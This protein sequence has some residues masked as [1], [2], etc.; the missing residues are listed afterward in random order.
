MFSRR[1]G[2]L[3]HITSLPSPW[4]LGD[5]GPGA[6]EFID[7]LARAKQGLWQ[8]LP[9]NPTTPESFHS[10]YS[11]MSAFAGNPL[12]ISPELLVKDGF[13]TRRSLN[14]APQAPEGKADF[15]LSLQIRLPLLDQAFNRF[16]QK[17]SDSLYANFC[18][19]NS[20][21]LD[22]FALF[23]AMHHH[24]NRQLW[25][26]WPV[27]LR[28][29]HADAI[30]AISRELAD[31]IFKVK[32]Q[33]YLFFRQWQDLRHYCHDRG[34]GL[35][36]DLP[37]YV[38][39]DSADVWS[40]PEVFQLDTDKRPSALSGMPPSRF[41]SDGQLWGMPLFAWSRLRRRNYSWW[42]QRVRQNIRM[43]DW[44]RFD[45]FLGLVSYWKIPIGA[46]S[47]GVGRW[48]AG[49]RDDFFRVLFRR[50]SHV[51]IVAEDLGFTSAESAEIL[52]RYNLPG[53]RVLLDA[54]ARTPG[55]SRFLPHNH[56]RHCVVYTSTH[57]SNTVRGWHDNP[58]SALEV[59][60]FQQ[61]VGHPV[62]PDEA[63]WEMIR[64]AMSS[65]ANSA[66]IQ[67]QDVLGL[68]EEARMN[69][70]GV[71]K[72]NWQWRLKPDQLSDQL[73]MRLAK[74]AEMY[75]RA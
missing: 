12:L 9:L 72:G 55:L 6:Y 57:D 20:H 75:S 35:F 59:E 4:G 65:V 49:P 13:L 73:A 10:P 25:C 64:L 21:W 60:N 17:R 34:I 68:S 66:M 69:R 74:L 37:I 29:R 31:E 32:F 19:Q 39:Y 2:I 3:L 52:A 58:R 63:P 50:F 30:E 5:L 48:M 28:D 67:M 27:E 44:V 18:Q 24:F 70:P 43:Y 47:A 26:D 71:A 41:N 16:R 42:V 54:F 46:E 38:V 1:S 51:P 14:N 53:M 15:E 8:M 23:M 45:H 22:D 40:H 33:Q 61:Y 11:G 7:F 56:V 36:G 62:E